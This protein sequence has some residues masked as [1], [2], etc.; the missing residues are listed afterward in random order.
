MID[1]GAFPNT[2]KR[3]PEVISGFLK[4]DPSDPVDAPPKRAEKDLADLS[5]VLS[6][7]FGGDNT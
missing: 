7:L 3:N 2:A 5:F 1:R 6:Y 4:Q